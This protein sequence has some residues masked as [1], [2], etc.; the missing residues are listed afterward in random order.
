MKK[1]RCQKLWED[2]KISFKMM[3]I[4]NLLFYL[5]INETDQQF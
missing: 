1:I 5:E 2:F 4:T 3:I